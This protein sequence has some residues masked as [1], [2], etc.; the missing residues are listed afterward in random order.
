MKMNVIIKTITHICS[1]ILLVSPPSNKNIELKTLNLITTLKT[2]MKIV[3]RSIL[4]QV[5][6]YITITN[7]TYCRLKQS[8]TYFTYFIELDRGDA[9]EIVGP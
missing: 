7:L 9:C 5:K 3:T 2:H 8:Q 6:H 4:I 1:L